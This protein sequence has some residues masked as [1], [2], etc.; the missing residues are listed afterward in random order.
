MSK[1]LNSFLITRGNLPLDLRI[2]MKKIIKF[3]EKC[4]NTFLLNEALIKSDEILNE[5]IMN[6]QR[7]TGEISDNFIGSES[8]EA[9]DYQYLKKSLE[10]I[11]KKPQKKLLEE[12]VFRVVQLCKKNVFYTVCFLQLENHYKQFWM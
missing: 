7:S 3:E 12:E 10:I 11:K 9:N 2:E 5:L 6:H 8:I 4:Y 1:D